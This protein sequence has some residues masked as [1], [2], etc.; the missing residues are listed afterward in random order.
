MAILAAIILFF[1]ERENRNAWLILTFHVGELLLLGF[2]LRLHYL[3]SRTFVL[4]SFFQ[5][6][7]LSGL[8]LSAILISNG[9]YMFEIREA[10]DANGIVWVLLLFFVVG[11]ECSAIAYRHTMNR[12]RSLRV[13]RLSNSL[14][15]IVVVAASGTALLTAL[16]VL[17][18]YSGPI[19]LGVDRVTFWRAVVPDTLSFVP[20]LV[21]Q[22]FYF[23]AFYYQWSRKRGRGTRFAIALVLLYLLLTVLVLGQKLS[24]FMIYMSVWS[25]ILAGTFPQFRIRLGHYIWILGLSL[26]LLLG[27][28]ISYSA[29]DKEAV[30]IVERVALQAQL[31]WSTFH[32]TSLPLLPTEDWSC[33]FG[34]GRFGDGKDYISYQYLPFAIYEGYSS[35]GAELSGWMPALPIFTF[36]LV[37]AVAMHA[38]IAAALGYLQAKVVYHLQNSN[39][40]LSF[41]LFKIQLGLT[42]VWYAAMASAWIGL[43]LVSV[44]TLLYLIFFSHRRGHSRVRVF[45]L[46]HHEAG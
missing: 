14:T 46:G 28:V 12:L 39:L 33:Y 45:A 34:C 11:L 15:T 41:L 6:Y 13:A 19:V 29:A 5:I 21:V 9:A 4:S 16:F 40:I 18:R 10:G 24:A 8:L 44:V 36:G 20:T 3:A 2:Y 27:L 25:I 22:T 26:L 42:L 23:A 31:L 32:G 38:A 1:V 43:V 37:I 7:A 30:F 35:S 17:I